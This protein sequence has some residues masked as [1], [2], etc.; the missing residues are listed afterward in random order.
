MASKNDEEKVE[1][2]TRA[3]LDAAR[4]EGRAN[5]DLVQ[6]QHAVKFTPEVLETLTAMREDNDLDLVKDVAHQYKTLVD[7][8]DKTVS[9]TVTTAVPMDDKL[10][11]DV[12]AKM[13]K[14]LKAPIYLV[15]RVDPSIIGGIVIEARGNRYDASV[16]AQL[17]NI[18]KKLSTS[19]L[20][21]EE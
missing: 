15:E 7:K 16:K 20:G 13:E 4:S 6:W 5:A 1:A 9:V 19:F 2:Y 11:A 12:H 14:D 18:R 17:V 21:G 10:R 3:L 8:D